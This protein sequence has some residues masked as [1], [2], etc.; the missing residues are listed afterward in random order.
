M[1]W[2][3]VGTEPVLQSRWIR[4]L[5]NLYTKREG[6]PIEEYYVVERANFVLVVAQTLTDVVLVRQYRP[7]T[8]K[9][10]LCLPA[11]YVDAEEDPL[12]A[13]ARE[14]REET[15]LSGSDY[16][17]VGVLDPM[18][19]YLCSRGFVVKCKIGTNASI[20]VKDDEVIE[21]IQVPLS[22][23]LD[24]IRE[25]AINEMQAVAALLLVTLHYEHSK[26]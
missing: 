1:K 24:L 8:D 5:R 6:A 15:G 19:G 25:G 23:V 9:C 18:P 20:A 11:G 7:A 3:L 21:V 17:L 2:K 13:A 14:L 4:V 22:D 10:Y 26:T 16:Q 12:A